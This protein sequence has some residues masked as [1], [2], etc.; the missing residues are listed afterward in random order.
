M[1]SAIGSLHDDDYRL[2]S[3]S[4]PDRVQRCIQLSGR[5]VPG[6]AA[7]VLLRGRQRPRRLHA[8]QPPQRLAP[9][10]GQPR[11]CATDCVI[12]YLFYFFTKRP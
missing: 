10:G 8:R 4:S 6:C 2:I 11:K 7:G 3:A 1:T 9:P 12:I 5:A